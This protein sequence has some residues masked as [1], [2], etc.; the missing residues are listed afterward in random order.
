M[1]SRLTTLTSGSSTKAFA[2]QCLYSRDKLGIDPEKYNVN[3][4][5][6]AIGHPFGMTGTRMAGHILQEGK[7]RGAKLGVVTMCIGGG[8]A[9]GQEHHVTRFDSCHHH[10]RASCPIGAGAGVALIVLLLIARIV[11]KRRAS[12]RLT[13]S[14]AS[15]ADELGITIDT[16]ASPDGPVAQGRVNKHLVEIGP[17][18]RGRKGK[19]VNTRYSVKYEATEAPK[20]TLIKRTPGMNVPTIDTGNRSFD[21]V[22]AV[23]TDQ[24]VLFAKFFTSQRRAA[25]VRM[26][27]QWPNAEIT[28]RATHIETPN[29]ERRQGDM[30]DTICHLVATA[31]T[32]DRPT[33]S[34]K[35]TS[36][37]SAPSAAIIE[38]TELQ[39][40]DTV[41]AAPAVEALQEVNGDTDVLTVVRLDE[42]S[43]IHELFDTGLTQSEIANRFAQHYQG[44]EVTWTGEVVRV[45][46]V[47]DTGV[48]RIA[49]LIGSANGQDPR[50]GRVVAITTTGPEPIL[51]QGDITT[52]SGTLV[53]LN[54]E[55]RLFHLS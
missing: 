39:T 48:Q 26:L 31:E 32:F 50:S 38:E 4:G 15:A 16:N 37:T 46:A 9:L 18:A 24:P 14:W 13:A 27:A 54:A 36:S 33:K 20:F 41:M 7:R 11:R 5:S 10:S 3:G 29:L 40:P 55:Q 25:V 35:S 44:R 43:V 1:A 8:Q 47:E 28:N 42:Q 2:S 34:K 49:A 51:V 23:E 22:I 12:K 19:H 21:A 17:I 53:N 52:F 6:I 45:G 30:V